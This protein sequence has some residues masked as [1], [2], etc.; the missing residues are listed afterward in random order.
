LLNRV[1]EIR[2]AVDYV[3]QIVS[4]SPKLTFILKRPLN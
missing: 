3:G 2:R 1:Q 4:L